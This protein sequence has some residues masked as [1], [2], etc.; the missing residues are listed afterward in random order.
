MSYINPT[1]D[2]LWEWGIRSITDTFN[3]TL[4]DGLVTKIAVESIDDKGNSSLEVYEL[5][6]W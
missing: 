5:E 3:Y 2:P 4:E 6:W 1:M